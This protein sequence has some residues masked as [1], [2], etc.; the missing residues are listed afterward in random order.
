MRRAVRVVVIAFCVGLGWTTPAHADAVTY[1]N[2]VT[3]QAVTI[4]RPGGHGFLDIA[5]VQA[6][7]H[8]AVQSIQRRFEPYAA[9]VQGTGSADA[10]AAA[11]AYGVL[12][13]IYPKQRRCST[14]S[15][16]RFSLRASSPETQD[17]WS[18]SR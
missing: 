14:R 13:G 10:A 8:D 16:Q 7:V 6:A 12:K 4:G 3:V 11:A 17:W 1:W 18:A 15:T 5:L 2:D 9:R